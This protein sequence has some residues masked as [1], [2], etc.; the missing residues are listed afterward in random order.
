MSRISVA[1]LAH[2]TQDETDGQPEHFRSYHHAR[3]NAEDLFC[4]FTTKFPFYPEQE[5]VQVEDRP[6][7]SRNLALH[8]DQR[9][10]WMI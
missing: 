1:Q 2:A 9:I 5:Q 3:K 8:N 6:L 10:L 7:R 4:M